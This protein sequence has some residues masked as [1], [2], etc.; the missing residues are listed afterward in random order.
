MRSLARIAGYLG[1]TLLFD[2]IDKR[3]FLIIED[4]V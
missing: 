1:G 3:I 4:V 2:D